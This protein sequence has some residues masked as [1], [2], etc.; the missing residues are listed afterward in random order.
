M[1]WTH[2]LGSRAAVP[3]KSAGVGGSKEEFPGAGG[4]VSE[5]ARRPQGMFQ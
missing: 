2:W 1:A 4:L 3:A 5:A